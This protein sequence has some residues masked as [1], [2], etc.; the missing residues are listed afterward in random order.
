M[1]TKKLTYLV[2]AT[3]SF[4]LSFFTLIRCMEEIRCIIFPNIIDICSTNFNSILSK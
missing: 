3:V 4:L 1:K 2:L